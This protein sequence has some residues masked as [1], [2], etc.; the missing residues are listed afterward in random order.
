VIFSYGE[1]L[2]RN[3]RWKGD[4]LEV[5][6]VEQLRTLKLPSPEITEWFRMGLK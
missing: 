5:A 4:A 3:F 6:I 2:T 1:Q